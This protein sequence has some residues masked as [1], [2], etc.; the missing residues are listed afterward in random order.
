VPTAISQDNIGVYF[1]T[2][3]SVWSEL[4]IAASSVPIRFKQ[5]ICVSHFQ[6]DKPFFL[7]THLLLYIVYDAIFL[8]H[9]LY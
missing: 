7:F 4:Y 9:W 6:R 3:L 1:K 8:L 2:I 5:N